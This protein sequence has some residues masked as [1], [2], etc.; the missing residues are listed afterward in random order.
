MDPVTIIEIVNT[1]GF[2]IACVV[3]MFFMLNKERET[4][5]EETDKMIEALNNNTLVLESIKAIL[6]ERGTDI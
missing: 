3:A 1:V 6:H 4:H 5:K 2:P